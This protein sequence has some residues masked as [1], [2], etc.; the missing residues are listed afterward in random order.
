MTKLEFL[1]E[2]NSDRNAPCEEFSAKLADCRDVE[3][4]TLETESFNRTVIDSVRAAIAKVQ[5]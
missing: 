4:V 2:W 3:H 1:R 5:S